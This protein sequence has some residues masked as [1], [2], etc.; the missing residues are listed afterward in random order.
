M[1]R[2][3]QV[4][5]NL[6]LLDSPEELADYSLKV[7]GSARRQLLILSDMLDPYVYDREDVCAALSEFARRSRYTDVKIL[8]RDSKHL[9]ERGHRLARLHQKLTSKIQLRQLTIEPNDQQMAYLCA[10]QRQLVYKNDDQVHQGFVH[11]DDAST[12]KTLA[13]EFLR[14]W[15][16]ATEIPDLRT[17][18]L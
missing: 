4:D 18:H 3:S 8:I 9:I 13:E 17:L 2:K 1:A 5:D 16:F 15:E 6:L 12:A 11:Y 7:I 10:D 14:L